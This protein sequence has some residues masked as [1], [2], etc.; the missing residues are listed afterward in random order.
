MIIDGIKVATTPITMAKLSCGHI[1]FISG[2]GHQIGAEVECTEGTEGACHTY[3]AIG[4]TIA[5][6]F[7]T[8][9]VAVVDK[10][11]ETLADML[12]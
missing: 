10:T 3:D 9:T 4:C 12:S 11:L 2:H 1:E 7:E 6:V 5:E 8:E